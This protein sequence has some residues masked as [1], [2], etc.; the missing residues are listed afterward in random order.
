MKNTG[1]RIFFSVVAFGLAN[2]ALFVAAG[3]F[4]SQR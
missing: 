2:I 4:T 1:K 3:S